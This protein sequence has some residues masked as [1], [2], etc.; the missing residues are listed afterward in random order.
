MYFYSFIFMYITLTFT[1][2]TNP[3]DSSNKTAKITTIRLFIIYINVVNFIPVRYVK[4]FPD[5]ILHSVLTAYVFRGVC[6]SPE[7][8]L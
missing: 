2:I 3:T 6:I 5:A 7:K 4:L 8:L 1:A